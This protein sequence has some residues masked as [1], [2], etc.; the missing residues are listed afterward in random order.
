MVP[1][2]LHDVK[3]SV[4]V[5]LKASPGPATEIELRIV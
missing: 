2:L 1:P 4:L 3:V 5:L